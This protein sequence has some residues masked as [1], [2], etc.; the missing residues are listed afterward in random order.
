VARARYA[1]DASGHSLNLEITDMGG[2]KGLMA[3]A[4]WANVEEDKQTQTGYEKTYRQGGNMVHEQWDSAAR[5]GEFGEVIGERFAVKLTG[6]NT[7]VPTLKSALAGV[8]L[9]GLEAL[10]NEGVK[11]N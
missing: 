8:D 11:P 9:S 10:K 5:H 6:D 1:D 2:A 3:L 4:S 7:D